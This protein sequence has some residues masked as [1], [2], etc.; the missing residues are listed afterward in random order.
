MKRI[1]RA[2]VLTTAL[3]LAFTAVVLVAAGCGDDKTRAKDL[4]GDANATTSDMNTTV[5]DIGKQLSVIYS[6]ATAQNKDK[7]RYDKA[8][9][10][11]EQ[12]VAKVSKAVATMRSD[13]EQVKKLK[14]VEKYKEYADVQLQVLDLTRQSMDSINSFLK[15]V[16]KLTSAGTFDQAAFTAAFTTL[17]Q[18]LSAQSAKSAPLV[19][20]AE[21]LNAQNNLL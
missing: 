11:L 17:R 8:Q 15:E 16:G 13:F 6:E 18:E 9:G 14:G 4:V 21:K 10:L 7:T 1:K 12:Q 3:T 5:G 19:Q 20:Q 2:V